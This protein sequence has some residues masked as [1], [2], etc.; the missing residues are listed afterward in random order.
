EAPPMR[1]RL[2]V[3]AVVVI[4]AVTCLAALDLRAGRSGRAAEERTDGPMLAHMV[5]FTLKD[6]TP[7]NRE[8]LVA[9]CKKHLTGHPGTVYFSAGSRAEEFDREVNDKDFDVALHLV[10]KDKAAHDA[11]QDHPR[12]QDFINENKDAWA[13][14]RVFDSYVT[15]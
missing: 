9:A 6:R 12:H 13:K 3:A 4:A 8:R 15:E 11:Y 1:T 5:F 14:V 10:F 7:Q 2:K